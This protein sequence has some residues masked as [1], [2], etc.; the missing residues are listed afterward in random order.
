MTTRS[1]SRAASQEENVPPV[2]SFGSRD[3]PSTPVEPSG[4]MPSP[5]GTRDSTHPSGQQSVPHHGDDGNGT[6]GGAY[7]FPGATDQ[8]QHTGPNSGELDKFLNSV[9]NY[10]YCHMARFLYVSKKMSQSPPCTF[11]ADPWQ[12]STKRPDDKRS[13]HPDDWHDDG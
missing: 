5:P 7:P 8:T 11:N 2:H 6:P 13:I 3:I 9:T 10:A 1:Q 4:Q 12:G